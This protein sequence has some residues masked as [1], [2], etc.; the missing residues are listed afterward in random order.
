[1]DNLMQV[2]SCNLKRQ[3]QRCE[4][5]VSSRTTRLCAP[6]TH[7]SRVCVLPQYSLHISNRSSL[8]EATEAHKFSM[9]VPEIQTCP[10]AQDEPQCP[11]LEEDFNKLFRCNSD[12]LQ[13]ARYISAFLVPTSHYGR[14]SPI[15]SA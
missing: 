1:M 6:V 4:P 12:K 14:V 9:K 13:R 15:S 10:W 2:E 5:T 3:R 8:A 11:T 7:V